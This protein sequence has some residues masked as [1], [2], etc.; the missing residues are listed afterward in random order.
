MFE[1]RIVGGTQL[2]GKTGKRI[3]AI[4]ALVIVILFILGMILSPL[5]SM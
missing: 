2:F 1:I 5:L 4:V 3:V